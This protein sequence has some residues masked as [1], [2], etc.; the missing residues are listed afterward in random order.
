MKHAITSVAEK[1]LYFSMTEYEHVVSEG[2]QRLQ[3]EDATGSL[4][5]GMTEHEHV[6]HE[7]R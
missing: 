3:T 2:H 6:A 5:T 7:V 4:L 1:Y